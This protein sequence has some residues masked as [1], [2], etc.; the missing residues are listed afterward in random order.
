MWAPAPMI[1]GPRTVLRSSLAPLLDD[2]PALDLGVDQLPVHPAL[3]VLEHQAVGLQHV[4]QAA[5]VLPP[6]RTMCGS[7]RLPSSIRAW[8]ASV[9]SSSPRAEGSIDLA[10]AKIS[11]PN[12]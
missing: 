9:I 7:T 8:I 4:L 11:G 5:R 3:Q 12:M 1:A 2:D 6:A 10:A